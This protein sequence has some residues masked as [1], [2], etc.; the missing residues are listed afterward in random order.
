MNI[1]I[2]NLLL[3]QN[4]IS[5]DIKSNIANNNYTLKNPLIMLNAYKIAPLTALIAFNCDDIGYCAIKIV[6]KDNNHL[7]KTFDKETNSHILPILGLYPD[8]NNTIEICY[9][10][11]CNIDTNTI[12]NLSYDDLVNNIKFKPEIYTFNIKTD[13][14]PDNMKDI[15]VVKKSTNDDLTF[16][17]ELYC[18]A[19]DK[20]GEVRWYLTENSIIPGISPIC[21]LKNGNIMVMNNKLIHHL[22]YV[23]GMFEL[24]LLG[25]IENEYTINGAHHEILEL[26]NGDL[27]VACEKDDVTTEDYIVIL[28]RK[29]GEIKKD[30]DFKEILEITHEADPTYQ[31]CLYAYRRIMNKNI[32]DKQLQAEVKLK[33]LFDWLHMNSIYYS[34]DEHYIII[35][36][37]VKDC[38][39]KID[40][41]TKEIIWIFTD[42]NISWC[43]EYKNKIL[44]PTNFD[45]PNYCYGQHSAKI[46]PE[47]LL[48][49]FDNGNFRSKDFDTATPPNENYS[50]GVAYS[51]DEKNRTITQEFEFGRELEDKIYSCYLG[52]IDFIKKDNYI[53]S[54][55]GIIYDNENNVYDAPIVIEDES[56]SIKAI[57]IEVEKN[58]EVGRYVIDNTNAY[59]SYRHN[60]YDNVGQH[61]LNDNAKMI[62]KGRNTQTCNLDISIEQM[63]QSAKLD[64]TINFIND[65]G[66]RLV[67]NINFNNCEEDSTKYLVFVSIQDSNDNNNEQNMLVFQFKPN[68]TVGINK[69]TLDS[70]G[71]YK[72]GLFCLDRKDKFDWI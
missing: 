32:P 25:K 35:S 48:I 40:S 30:Y 31:C 49:I 51:I 70:L 58:I 59:R 24:N 26:S 42:D 64:Y 38:V 72:V 57:I 55:G 63:Q 20:N 11:S 39:I 3:E 22:Y 33:F 45:R 7:Y 14:L 44:N 17:S 16:F 23:S 68:N 19:F 54:F 18:R 36:S 69:C 29:T 65:I 61:I 66:D 71:E 62:G 5:K 56:I 52:S 6:G 50:R 27:M 21:Y 67:F 43:D 47:G 8:Y 2:K 28:D 10:K 37:R 53:I 41:I 60:I 15:E 12:T 46:T 4:N 9:I 1:T 34:E 13:K